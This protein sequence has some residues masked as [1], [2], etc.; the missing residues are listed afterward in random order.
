M[1]ISFEET[2]RDHQLVI[3]VEEF[4]LDEDNELYPMAVEVEAFDEDNQPFPLTDSE[5]ERFALRASEL[6]IQGLEKETDHG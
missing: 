6:Y 2:V 4:E 3:V 5:V 1:T